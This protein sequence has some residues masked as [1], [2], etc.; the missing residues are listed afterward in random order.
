MLLQYLKAWNLQKY[1]LLL[2]VDS[3]TNEEKFL[4]KAK[5]HVLEEITFL[6]TCDY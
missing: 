6:L 5:F 2:T 1:I 3:L 4:A